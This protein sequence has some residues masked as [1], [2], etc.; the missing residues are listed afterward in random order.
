MDLMQ[1]VF[2]KTSL[3]K[4]SSV[5]CAVSGRS[6]QLVQQGRPWWPT[7]AFVQPQRACISAAQVRLG[8]WIN[9]GYKI[10]MIKT[11][12]DHIGACGSPPFT[13]GVQHGQQLHSAGGK[14]SS[15]MVQAK[16]HSF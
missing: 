14:R 10:A 8:V 16:L 6:V 12:V 2:A 13:S 9:M 1:E 15:Q 11:G 4:V 7:G 3:A 5:L